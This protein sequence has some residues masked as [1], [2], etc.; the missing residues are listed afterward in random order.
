MKATDY[1]LER[2]YI[3]KDRKAAIGSSYGGYM[4]SWIAGHTDR[5]TCL[6]NHAGVYNTHLMFAADNTWY[7][8][9]QYDGSPWED[10]D[11]MME[12]NPAMFA[13]NFKTPMLIYHGEK[14]YRVVVANG[15]LVYGIYKRMGLDARFV[16]YPDENHHILSPQNSIYWYKELHN[17]L[18]RYLSPR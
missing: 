11:I 7:R 6:V 14:D 3:D 10:F 15:L 1:M 9:H 8:P 5:F 2:D 13:E 4:A 17:W 16:Y 12:K 18:D